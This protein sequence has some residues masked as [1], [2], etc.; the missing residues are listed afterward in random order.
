MNRR[1]FLAAELFAYSFDNYESH[2]EVGNRRF[3]R[4]MP[5]DVDRLERADAEK[6]P[7]AKIASELDVPVSDVA[8]LKRRFERAKDVVDAPTP[9]EAFRRGVRYSIMDAVEEGLASADEIEQLVVQVCYRAADLGLLLDLEGST[10]SEYS[11]ALR[12]EP[13]TDWSDEEDVEED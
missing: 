2:L 13:E 10:L 6:W 8:E 5:A 9:A 3:T 7:D 1:H 12:A 11:D 4:Y